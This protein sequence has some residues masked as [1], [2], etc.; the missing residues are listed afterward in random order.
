MIRKLR[1]LTIDYETVMRR[2]EVYEVKIETRIDL[3]RRCVAFPIIR[4]LLT[5]ADSMKNQ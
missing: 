4:W 1:L 2:A 5:L 3:S